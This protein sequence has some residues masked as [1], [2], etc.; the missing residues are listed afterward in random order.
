M[1]SPSYRT[2]VLLAWIATATAASL[3]AQDA[4]PPAAAPTPPAA[5]ALPDAALLQKKTSEWIQTR[6]MIG[7]ETAA[8]QEEKASLADLN[9]IRTKETAQLD[10]VVKAAGIRIEELGTKKAALTQEQTDLKAWRAKLEADLAKLEAD[11][12]PLLPRFPA[13]LREKIEESLIRLESPEAD[14]PLQNRARDLLLVLQACTEFQNQLTID[15]EVREIG[16]ER[17]EV[18]VLYLGLTQAWYVDAAGKHSG[19]GVPGDQGWTWTEDNSLAA[20]VRSAIEIQAR[21]AV[22]AFVE[23]PLSNQASAKEAAK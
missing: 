7:E 13:P 3:R 22:P 6:R 12:L 17:R 11:L 8:W 9:A 10:E 19:H 5:P 1:P 14:Q 23:L 18:E 21:R 20:R 16:G 2:L 4:A 15:S